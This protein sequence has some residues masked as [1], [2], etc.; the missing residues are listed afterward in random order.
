PIPRLPP[1]TRAPRAVVSDIELTILA[2]ARLAAPEGR[3]AS[4]RRQRAP[5]VLASLQPGDALSARGD[6]Q[7]AATRR[8]AGAGQGA[9]RA[10]AAVAPHR[11]RRSAADARARHRHD[12][13]APG[14]AD[15][16]RVRRLR[17]VLQRS[18]DDE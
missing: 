4:A 16:A 10:R 5:L 14:R 17:D 2:H 12:G 11:T 15:A 3:F 18:G 7:L 1:G 8:P 13:R 9:G 6:A